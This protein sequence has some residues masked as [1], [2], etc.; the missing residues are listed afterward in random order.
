[1]R[2]TILL[3]TVFLAGLTAAATAQQPGPAFKLSD[4]AGVWD[5]KTLGPKDS[6][7]VT[8]VETITADGKGWTMTF[9]KGAPI[10]VRLVNTAGDSIVT[11]AGPFPSYLRPG[12]TVTLLR[13][14]SHYKGNQMWGTAV[15]RYAGGE[16]LT[17]QLTATR[18]K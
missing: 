5:S 4:V 16:T 9:P 8:T 11:E 7:L 10:A 13:T 2:P 14:V 1:M 12:Q 15:A 6:V 18:R 3:S 17:F